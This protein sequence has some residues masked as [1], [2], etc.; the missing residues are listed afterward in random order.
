[1]RKEKWEEKQQY[2]YSKWQTGG[3]A[4]ENTWVCLR[5]G[6]LYKETNSLLIEAK[7]TP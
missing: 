4:H 3:I 6:N 7:M 1:M 5:K 2:V